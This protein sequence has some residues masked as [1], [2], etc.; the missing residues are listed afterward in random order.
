MARTRAC[1]SARSSAAASALHGQS[2]CWPT[3]SSPRFHSSFAARHGGAGGFIAL[4]NT[5]PIEFLLY[6]YFGKSA[7]DLKNFTLRD[8]GVLRTNRE[9]SFSARF[10]ETY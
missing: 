2:R 5:R 4:D 3:S 6:L 10:T 1:R 8:L 7:E 9:T